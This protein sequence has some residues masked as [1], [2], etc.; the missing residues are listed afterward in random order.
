M[1]ELQKRLLLGPRVLELRVAAVCVG[2]DQR[3]LP[4]GRGLE[5]GGILAQGHF[6]T[7]GVLQQLG[8]VKCLV[9]IAVM[10]PLAAG[11]HVD[12]GTA[13]GF[14]LGPGHT[15]QAAN[16]NQGNTGDARLFH[17]MAPVTG[18]SSFKG[19]PRRILSPIICAFRV[20]LL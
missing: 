14:L 17:R 11:E 5:N 12:A 15:G 19:R 3:V 2:D 1:H 6:I 20:S 16:Q 8:K 18:R 9:A 10:L 7:T 4:D 13:R